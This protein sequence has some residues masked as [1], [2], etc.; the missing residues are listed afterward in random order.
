MRSSVPVHSGLVACPSVGAIGIG[1]LQ[2]ARKM[3]PV[4]PPQLGDEWNARLE[5]PT[6]GMFVASTHRV[7]VRDVSSAQHTLYAGEA[8]TAL[9]GLLDHIPGAW[10]Y[11][12]NDPDSKLSL[13]LTGVYKVP[14]D[15][16]DDRVEA[17][18]YA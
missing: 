6:D 9:S 5:M 16:S 3:Q 2:H 8:F 15:A 10:Q 11:T 14:C 13:R 12:R 4:R 7:M 17:R 18:F 1:T